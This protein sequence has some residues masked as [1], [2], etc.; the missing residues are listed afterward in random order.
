MKRLLSVLLCMTLCLSFIAM[1]AYA[2]T[3][4]GN[5]DNGGGSMGSGTAR[6]IWHT[7][8]EG[9]RI[10]VVRAADNTPIFTP[11]D[12]TNKDESDVQIH[13]GKKSKLHYR[14]GT[15]LTTSQSAYNCSNPSESLP[16]IISDGGGN[17]NIKEIRSYF[18]D[19][20]VIKSLASIFGITYDK[21][22]NGKY[23]LL[24]EPIAYFTFEGFK[25]A[26]TATEAAL[27]DQ[28]L[29]GGLRRRMVSLSHQNLPLSMFLQRADL[30]YP[31]YSG[32]TS[33]PQ[34]DATIIKELGLGIVKFKDDGG[35]QP[36][37]TSPSSPTVTYRTNT[38]V[39][40]SVTLSSDSKITPDNP[41][42]VTFHIGGG[43]YTMTNVVM[44]AGESQLVWC[45]WHTPKISQTVDIR[46][47]STKGELSRSNIKAKIVSLNG[48]EPPDPT[49]DDRNNGFTLPSL[50]T[51]PTTTSNSWGVWSAHWVPHWVWQEDWEWHS[52]GSEDGGDWEDDGEWVDEGKWEYTFHSYR[53]TLS[54]NM[55]LTPSSRAWSAKGKEMKSGYGVEINVTSTVGS[56][57]PASHVTAAQ[58]AVTYFPE[59]EYTTYWR[60]LDPFVDKPDTVFHFKHNKYST[61]NDRVHFTPL[62]YPDGPYTVC[63][64][65][66]DAW[67]PAGM[68]SLP[69]SDSVTIKG[70]V[71]DD[72][73]IGP[74]LVD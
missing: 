51:M 15:A 53:A 31:A 18:T 9:V 16:K 20:Q 74:M 73:H 4:E 19:R 48:H 27:Y 8:E 10:T 68:L 30:G 72:W 2:G 28:K 45:K 47:S 61:Y 25:V 64:Y 34:S 21:L 5:I 32:S 58:T 36:D 14:N 67:T 62:W 54:A 3:G 22:T 55:S 1:P 17:R 26:M 65:L 63:T 69:L 38:D 42:K 50:P 40:T 46:V 44:P 35:T 57:A 71:Y 33:K 41:A 11:I 6:N 52:D 24:L 39:I 13:F 37:P 7:G 49:A 70:N 23:K 12:L 29:S 56:R 43:T 66:E 59:F 60:V